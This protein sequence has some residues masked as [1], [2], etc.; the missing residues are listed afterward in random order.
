[1]SLREA[2]LPAVS[3]I[4]ERP[5]GAEIAALIQERLAHSNAVSPPESNHSYGLEQLDRFNILFWT[6]RAGEQLAGCGALSLQPDGTAELKSMFL[7]PEWRGKGMSRLILGTIEAEAERRRVV[8]I[9]LETGTDS[10]VARALYESF[11]YTYCGPFGEYRDDP[12]SVFMTKHI[13]KPLIER[14]FGMR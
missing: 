11:G 1:L 2:S 3:V 13:V 5:V 9:D 14:Q 8:R 12:N 4:R 7:R 6:A 10:L